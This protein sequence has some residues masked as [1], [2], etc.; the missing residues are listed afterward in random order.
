MGCYDHRSVAGS[1]VRGQ[2]R[3]PHRMSF[4]LPTRSAFQAFATD[5]RISRTCSCCLLSPLR[6]RNNNAP[7]KLRSTQLN[8]CEPTLCIAQV[9]WRD[10]SVELA[11]RAL[12]GLRAT[13]EVHPV[14]WRSGWRHSPGTGPWNRPLEL[15]PGTGPWHR[16]EDRALQFLLRQ[17][18]RELAIM[19]G[20]QSSMDRKP[21][22]RSVRVGLD[23]A[24]LNHRHS[25]VSSWQGA[26]LRDGHCDALER[27]QLT[28]GRVFHG[29][30]QVRH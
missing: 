18:R 16:R 20:E 13:L 4:P 5:P 6:S 11:Y 10:W 25:E 19:I 22:A 28:L 12:D 9:S 1:T 7:L 2:V 23:A 26:H 8:Q 29:R 27:S 17:S 30:N 15:A 14:S 3:S 21:R 24:V